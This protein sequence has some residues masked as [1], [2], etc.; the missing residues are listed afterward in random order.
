MRREKLQRILP[1]VATPVL[2]LVLCG[3]WE[4]AVA[5]LGI[6][7]LILP[8]PSM[9]G[10]RLVELM[11]DP[12]TWQQAGITATETVL[13]FALAVLA[14]VVI[15][16]TLG[17]VFWLEVSLRPII[18]ALQVVPKVAFIPLLVIWFGFGMTSKIVISA[19][20]AFFP[21]MLNVL[22]GVKSLDPGHRDVMKSLNASKWQTFTNL[23]VRSIMPYLLAG[24]ESGI[25]FALIGTIVGEYLGGSEGLGYMVV[26]TLNQLDAPGLFGVVVML[27]ALGLVL[28]FCVFALKRFLIPWHESVYGQ[29]VTA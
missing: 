7:T 6:S 28:Y 17:K 24:M 15:G 12:V 1:W 20:L 26:S 2:V 10:A 5:R 13:G 29:G 3:V 27:S 23:E 9:I 18:V 14:G 4:V 21:I 11:R 19:M 25:I 22:L 8:P 16:V